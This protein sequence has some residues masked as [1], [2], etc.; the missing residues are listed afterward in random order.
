M[1][2][3]SSRVLVQARAYIGQ[4][5][6]LSTIQKKHLL[7]RLRILSGRHSGYTRVYFYRYYSGKWNYYTYVN[8]PNAASGSNTTYTSRYRLPYARAW[9]V[10]AYHPGD[11]INA[12]T[13]GPVKQFTVR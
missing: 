10:R 13:W 2:S 6:I 8:A 3:F 5:V 7:H 11:A 4:T 9:Y 12:A 1:A